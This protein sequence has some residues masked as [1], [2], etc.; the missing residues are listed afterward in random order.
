MYV[1]VVFVTAKITYHAL[2]DLLFI[3]SLNVIRSAVVGPLVFSS[4]LTC[5][6][7]LTF[8]Y[9]EEPKKV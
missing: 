8:G 1:S 9:V 7:E 3:L 4:G 2:Q 5:Q 6:I